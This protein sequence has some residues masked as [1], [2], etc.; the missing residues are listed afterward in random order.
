MIVVFVDFITAFS[1]I[2]L[3]E[4]GDKTQVMSMSLQTKYQQRKLVLLGVICGLF[5][6]MIINLFIALVIKN[7]IDKK[8]IDILAGVFFIFFA[9]LVLSEMQKNHP[10]ERLANSVSS[11]KN[12]TNLKSLYFFLNV[13]IIMILAEFGDG[14]QV[15]FISLVAHQSDLILTFI[16]GTLAIVLVN[17]FGVLVADIFNRYISQTVLHLIVFFL[18]LGY[19]GILLLEALWT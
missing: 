4:I 5:L 18:F 11:I 9:F 16:G 17:I 10:V 15:L 8:V 3:A 7:F 12:E 19:G 1:V 14:S 6:M 13:T 2:F